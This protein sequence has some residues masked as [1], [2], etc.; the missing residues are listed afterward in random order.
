MVL[1]HITRDFPPGVNVGILGRNGAGKSTLLRI[2]GGSEAPD[3]GT[4]AREARIS[5]PIGFAGGFNSKLSGRENLRFICRL[6]NEDYNKVCAFVEEFSELGEYMDMPVFTYS[7]GMRA[8]I[9]FGASMA[10]N[11]DYYLI[12]E[13][14]AVGDA[15][16][17]KK[18]EAIFQ[19]RRKNATLIMVSH[20]M[21][22]VRA[23]CDRLLV[24][25][26]GKLREFDSPDA[27]VQFY[28]DVCNKKIS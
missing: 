9:N 24:L 4:V 21:G 28:N 1:D 20:S 10:F 23:L 13:V 18:S 22:T 15:S 16:F 7:S 8:K 6:Y 11:F 2:I 17:K 19:E 26:G 27:A 12:D 3:S 25:H 14:T 5:W